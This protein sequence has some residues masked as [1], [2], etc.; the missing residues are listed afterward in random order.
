VEKE[1]EKGQTKLFHDL[2]AQ[3]VED[4]FL[5][6]PGVVPVSFHLSFFVAAHLALGAYK[7]S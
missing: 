4:G 2:G 7:P 6:P 3:W 5:G 1:T